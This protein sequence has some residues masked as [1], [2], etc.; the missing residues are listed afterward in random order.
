[1]ARW[2]PGGLAQRE[3]LASLSALA[4]NSGGL[5]PRSRTGQAFPSRC[6][7]VGRAGLGPGLTRYRLC[8]PEKSLP[9]GAFLETGEIMPTNLVRQW[10]GFTEEVAANGPQVQAQE[11]GGREPLAPGLGAL[12]ALG[13]CRRGSECRSPG[14]QS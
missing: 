11:E 8:E 3:S 14:L 1:M 10:R 4:R 5:G 9:L 2:R 12:P 6:H 13:G 7:R